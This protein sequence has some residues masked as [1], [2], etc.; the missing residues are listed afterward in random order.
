MAKLKLTDI[1]K[2]Y[3]GA[4]TVQALKGVS[5]EFRENEFVS[6]LGPSG[7]GKTTLLNIIGGLDRYDSGDLNIG[8]LSTKDFKDADWDAYRNR[9]IGFVFQNY[10]LITHQTVLQ[11]VEIAMTLSGVSAVERRRRAK[12]ALES[13]GLGDQM[14]K[15]PNQMSGGQMQRVAIARA[16]V[17]NPDIILAD[18]PTGALD[19]QT[20]VQV[21]E[22]L[23][24]ISAAKLVI[25]VTH[26]GEIAEK[27]SSRIIRMLDGEIHSDSNP[28]FKDGGDKPNAKKHEHIIDKK[29]LKKTSM[30]II[31]ASTLSFKNLITKKG[32]TII[33]SFAGSIGIIGVALV[34]AL[35]TGLSGYMT[36]MQIESLAGMPIT[37]NETPLSIERGGG[38]G[39]NPLLSRADNTG[40]FT[41]ENVLIRHDIQANIIEHR[42]VLTE[43]YFDYIGKIQTELPEAVS[44]VNY[45][46]AVEINLLA[47]GEDSI[48]KF[49]TSSK[50]FSNGGGMGAM[51]GGDLYWM[52]M[53]D[54]EELILSL[55]DLI[56]EGS[57]FPTKKNEI[58]IVVDEYNRIDKA[59]FEK[60]GMFSETDNYE[61][62]DF[63][64]Q[65]IL[66][67]ITNDA[68]YTMNEDGLFVPAAASQY[69]ALYENGDG[70]E[71]T[72]TGILRI[73]ENAASLTNYLSSGIVYTTDLTDFIIENAVQSK[74]ASAQ[75]DSDID[76]IL[77]TPFA[78][79]S[80]KRARLLSLG[81]DT[82]PIGINIYPRDFAG[83]DTIKDYLDAY[84]VGRTETEQIVYSDIAQMME[85]M[86]GTMLNTISL[87]LIGFS[88]VSLLVSTIMIAII[89]YVSVLERTK[90]IGILRSVGARKKDIS[91]VFNAEAIIVGLTAGLLGIGISYLLTIPINLIVSSLVGIGSIA[92]LTLAHA[93]LL[94]LGSMTL[95]LIAGF[96]PS[97]MAAKK[98]PV[99]A[100]R[101]E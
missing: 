81:A 94:V 84:N 49:E 43:E 87:V 73:K 62:T 98:D 77:N 40:K 68:Y 26:N 16:L 64:G 67:V 83:K 56:G 71:L 50:T 23:K 88:A 60:L 75:K 90:E 53:E 45:T 44:M 14:R 15:K 27:Y 4:E 76:V 10:N 41:D 57:S 9:S 72:I 91:R 37:V 55:Y 39:D 59:F 79:E 63:I 95:T 82:A 47:K 86:F 21:M 35:S 100:L 51:L 19:S 17:N 6:I 33:T 2:T 46:R 22:I 12:E 80:N 99:E 1:T 93:G 3:H 25:M 18:E 52:E 13:V 65:T 29:T 101:T 36:Q 28:I 54:N 24:K 34:L 96:I 20:S 8:G 92:N 32:R 70:V 89:T 66:K 30:S 69:G 78:D 48:V 58:A 11:N 38:N 74:I 31:T 7:C 42:N 5:L 85:S 61:L 97:K